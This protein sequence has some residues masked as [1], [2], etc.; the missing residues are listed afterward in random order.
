MKQENTNIKDGVYVMKKWLTLFM[1][2]MFTIVL[3]ACGQDDKTTGAGGGDA[4]GD[5]PPA[6][7]ETIK[8]THQLGET[9]VPKNPSRLVVFDFGIL[10]SVDKLGVEV[11]GV[12]QANIPA[13]LSKF[14]DKKYE[15]VG[16]LKEPDFEKIN[17]IDPDLI[18]ISGRQQDAYEE[19][20][21]IAPTIFLGVD[22]SKYME[23]FKSN[24]NTLGQIFGKEAEV[25]KEMAAIN[26]NIKALN[27]KATATGKKALIILANEGKI[28]AYGPGSRFGILHDVFGFGAIDPNI[29]VS[30]HG[31][32]ISNEYIVEMN[33]D[34]LFV[35]DRGAAVATGEG[36]S[37]AKAVVENELVKTTNAAKDGNIVYLNPDF[38]YLSGG[39][40]TS[41]SEMI[42]EVDAAIK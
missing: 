15:N 27:E 16:S 22:T 5:T 8:I 7:A 28:S 30:T 12:P 26:E 42:T 9:D 35:V 24:M 32:D 21:K 40:L 37:G 14:E 10:D 18:I 19:L 13:Y 17:S 41:V 6:E 34:Y 4:A 29:E 23:S 31:K 25:E 1:V 11:L 38:W 39:G 33:P 36:E 2:V 3:A 20:S